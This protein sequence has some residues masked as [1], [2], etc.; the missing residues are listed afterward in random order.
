MRQPAVA[1][2]PEAERPSASGARATRRRRWRPRT[3]SP[4]IAWG[5][6]AWCRSQENVTNDR[7]GQ[8]WRAIGLRHLRA[9]GRRQLNRPPE[10]DSQ[11]ESIEPPFLQAVD[12]S[13][14][15]R[16]R[17]P[18]S[19]T[20]APAESAQA[21]WLVTLIAG[22]PKTG[23]GLRRIDHISGAPV[24]SMPWRGPETFHRPLGPTCAI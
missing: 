21:T 19:V 2:G 18:P 1:P 13:R 24:T 20:L 16:S 8:R 7:Y 3:R 11:R 5:L 6:W 12:A 14:V 10:R 4:R 15:G 22:R 23:L 17:L 9:K